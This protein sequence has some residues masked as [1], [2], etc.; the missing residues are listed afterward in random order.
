MKKTETTPLL[1]LHGIKFYSSGNAILDGI[2]LD[3][4]SGEHWVLLGRNGAGKTTLVN[5]IYGSIWPTAGRINLFGETFGETPLQVLR[6][7]IGILDSS[8]QESALQKS[9]TVYEVLLTGFF[10]TIGFYRE[11]D[12]WEEKEAERI[13]EEHGFGAKRNQLFRTL[14]SGEKKKVLFLRA[15][16]TSPEFVILDEP[17]S[18]L[19]LTAREEFIDFL[20]AYKKNRTFTSI[21]ITHRIDE[22]PPFYEHAALLKSGRILYSGKIHE[23]FTGARLS[24]LYDRKVEAENRN[25]TWM[26]LTERT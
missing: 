22:I 14:S 10:H 23:A 6:N 5:L 7:K 1:S 25:G 13:L 26:A 24:N 11:S 16:C 21:Y 18:G 17:C 3:I 12:P 9:L 19:D 8:Q 20:D 15:M 4:R 2:D